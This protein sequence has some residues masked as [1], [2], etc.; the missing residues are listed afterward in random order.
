M[1]G[2]Q[3]L[4]PQGPSATKP[5]NAVVKEST[6]TEIARL[7][8]T[9]EEERQEKAQLKRM[10]RQE[11]EKIAQLE[12]TSRDEREKIAELEQTS[13]EE[14][15]NMERYE[16]DN[17]QLHHQ[18]HQMTSELAQE[19]EEWAELMAQEREERAVL[20]ESW[21][22]TP[23][24][25]LLSVFAPAVPSGVDKPISGDSSDDKARAFYRTCSLGDLTP[26][27]LDRPISAETA[28]K[29]KWDLES[30][31]K[32]AEIRQSLELRKCAIC[33]NVRLSGTLASVRGVNEFPGDQGRRPITQC[34]HV[35]CSVCLLRSVI[36]S[37]SSKWFFHLDKEMWFQCPVGSCNT[38]LDI[39]H[40]AELANVLRRL[41]YKGDIPEL[42]DRYVDS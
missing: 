31:A 7:M 30:K 6:E 28:L 42:L 23:R 41:E 19:R 39:P 13:Q 5:W 9:L 34:S 40:R 4:D 35:I 1:Q 38:Y 10:L 18:I 33:Q 14:R 21:P 16:I 27:L 8:K 25:V 3:S 20:M 17:E 29:F 22:Q 12:Q 36:G 37:F 24:M 15:E 32:R 26:Q 2:A 11:R